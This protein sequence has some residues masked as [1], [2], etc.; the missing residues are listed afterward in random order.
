MKYE[1]SVCM[2][3]HFFSILSLQ[4]GWDTSESDL[5]EGELEKQRRAL[6]EQLA[7]KP[8]KKPTHPPSCT[9]EVNAK[10]VSSSRC[11]TVGKILWLIFFFM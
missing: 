10:Y 4:T 5:S 9:Q 11:C 7:E 1:Y 6:L 8:L 3:I 2:N